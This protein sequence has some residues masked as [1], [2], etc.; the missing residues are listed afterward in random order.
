MITSFVI[1]NGKIFR[2]RVIIHCDRLQWLTKQN[3]LSPLSALFLSSSYTSCKFLCRYWESVPLISRVRLDFSGSSSSADL[4]GFRSDWFGRFAWYT[5]Q[6]NFIAFYYLRE[7]AGTRNISKNINFSRT[8]FKKARFLS[9]SLSSFPS[10]SL[11][12]AWLARAVSTVIC[13]RAHCTCI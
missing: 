7:R 6:M 12:L 10:L 11:S 4:R 9:F 3:D 8:Q 13:I 2:G 5:I 1:S